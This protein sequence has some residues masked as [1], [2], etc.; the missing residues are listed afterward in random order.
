[1]TQH[2]L[3]GGSS[4]ARILACPGSLSLYAALKPQDDAGDFAREGSMLHAVMELGFP[5]SLSDALI[6]T[7]PGDFGVVYTE[8]HRNT[9]IIPAWE[10]WR[11]YVDSH[12]DDM[13]V[14]EQEQKV[15]GQYIH[16]TAFGTADILGRHGKTL[17][18]GD[19]K[20]GDGIR[21]DVQDNKQM[22]FYAACALATPELTDLTEGVEQVDL[23][24]VQPMRESGEVWDVHT[25]PVAAVHA[26]AREYREAVHEGFAGSQ[27]YV[28]GSHC[29]FCKVK[30]DC[31]AQRRGVDELATRFKGA[32]LGEM[33][34]KADAAEEFIKALREEAFKALE[35]GV[36][37]PGWKLVP[38][39]AQR[40][41]VD[42][43]VA[44]STLKKLGLKSKD[45]C[46]P[47]LVSPAQAEKMLKAAGKSPKVIEPIVAAVSSG[48]TLAE[49]SDPRPAI[50]N[51]A[52]LGKL[53]EGR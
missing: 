53:V 45:I 51:L 47:E 16:A 44:I 46:P 9:K 1:M 22:L 28:L 21:V 29:R 32:E 48:S 35:A 41:W 52:A 19:W 6:G 36:A 10:A 11:E 49:A 13:L 38:K 12:V 4:A 2:S 23:L 17:V 26:F 7:E 30:L 24:I 20:F 27:K 37:V 5:D 39:R 50:P 43:D 42:S 31:P 25:V 40:K 18:V 15:V 3:I 33:L 14:F 8:E 34:K